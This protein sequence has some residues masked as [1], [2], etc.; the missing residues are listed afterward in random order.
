MK[1]KKAITVIVAL[2]LVLAALPSQETSAQGSPA[3]T[4]VTDKISVGNTVWF[5]NYNNAPV[6]WRVLGNGNDTEGGN[7]NSRL[8]LSVRLLDSTQFNPVGE[9]NTWQ[10]S[11]AQNWCESFYTNALSA[12]E[13]AA[14]VATT[15]DDPAYGFDFVPA[16]DKIL[17][18]D[19]VFFLS[20]QEVN[21][22]PFTDDISRIAYTLDG[23]VNDWWLRS[24]I[25][26]QFA[27]VITH[28]GALGS[29]P[30]TKYSTCARPAFNL[31]LPSVLFTSAAVGGKVSGP[32]GAGAL[33][34]VPETD[35]T[36]WKLTLLD[37]N[38]SFSIEW[39]S[40][41]SKSCT[42][43]YENATTGSNEYIS[44]VIFDYSNYR[45]KYYGHLA[46]PESS[47]GTLTVDFSAL[48]LTDNDTLFLF[49]EQY[50]G[51]LSFRKI[52]R[53]SRYRFRQSAILCQF[54]PNKY[55]M[56]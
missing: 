2:L 47:S 29:A 40:L 8:F 34:G 37:N 41:S 15:K 56:R 23:T 30:V 14:L 42:F 27:G 20:V 38:R 16:S 11:T 12:G 39:V 43:D 25:D 52:F 3:I 22:P 21:T 9:G 49:S 45:I 17:K 7:S 46:Q 24:P 53:D 31:Y 51:D 18:D 36:E 13:K 28:G 54:S 4:A 10:G 48:T 50:N 19:N 1:A 26:K 35:T 32:L 6:Q 33:K 5:G 55:L 44:A